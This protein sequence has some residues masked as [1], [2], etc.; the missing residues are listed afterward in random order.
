MDGL[1]RILEVHRHRDQPGTHDA[2][3]SGEIFGAIKR[4]ERDAVAAPQTA[5]AERPRHAV[6]RGIEL[7]EGEFARPLLAA[8]IDDRGFRQVAVADDQVAEIFEPGSRHDFGGEGGAVRYVPRPLA[9]SLP[10]RS[11]MRASAVANCDPART[12]LPWAMR[13]PRSAGR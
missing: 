4:Q 13:S 6:R 11:T 7:R 10:S 8:E 5:L 1:A 12:T 2:V 9:I 3:V